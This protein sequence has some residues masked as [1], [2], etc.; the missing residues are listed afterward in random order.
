MR[1]ARAIFAVS[2]LGLATSVGLSFVHPWGNPK[3]GAQ[4]DAPL[5]EGTG[6]PEDV[7]HVLMAKCADCHSENTH[8]PMYGRLAPAS[9]LMERDVMEGRSHLDLSQWRVYSLEK[10]ADLLTRMASEARNGEMPVK[11]YLYLH[12]GARLT[13]EE[14]DLIYG[15]AK[16]ERKHVRKK[17]AEQEE[18]T[19]AKEGVSGQ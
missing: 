14:Q 8:R 18:T 12:P 5:L 15:W 19:S 6:V 2:V 10:Q 7:R 16:T 17:L 11:Q 4:Q 1:V 13:P 9:W 3:M